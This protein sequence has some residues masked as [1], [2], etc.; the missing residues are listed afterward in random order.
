MGGIGQQ[1]V[2]GG[3]GGEEDTQGGAQVFSTRQRWLGTSH[4][5]ITP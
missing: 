2:Q 3:K 4:A 5:V 1:R